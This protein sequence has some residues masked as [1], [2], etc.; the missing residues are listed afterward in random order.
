[1]L[2]YIGR[3]LLNYAL[4]LYVAVSLTWLLAVTQLNPRALFELR[5]PPIAPETIEA[6]LALNN[7]SE[8]VPLWARCQP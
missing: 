5:Q 2:R 7:L 4:L 8:S 1:M 3:R 6:Q